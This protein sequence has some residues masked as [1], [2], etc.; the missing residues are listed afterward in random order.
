MPDPT[1]TT[2]P[3]PNRSLGTRDGLFQRNGWWWL[4]YHDAEGRRHRKKAAPD[5]D[6]AKKMYRATM[7]AI[8]RGEVLGVRDEGIRLREFVEKRYW[9]TVKPTLSA[10]E[11][12]R[13]RA[14]LDRQ[15]LPRFGDIRLSKLR[16]EDIERWPAERLAG[17]ARQEG[18]GGDGDQPKRKRARV[19]GVGSTVNKE[20][21]RLKHL[22]NRAVAWGYLRDNPARMV[23]RVKENP[24]RV[25]YLT[26]EERDALLEAAPATLH[27]CIVAAL[28]TGARRG[29]LL[30]LRCWLRSRS[31]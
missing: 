16:R 11:Q 9:P 18:K 17:K 14:T 22:L 3:R 12:S 13:A 25:R 20:L 21:M 30:G 5:Y 19:G 27:P 10:G 8:A 2:T 7:T 15:I 6:T 26:P 28:Q 29:E 24:G 1:K 31:P 23:K 4:D